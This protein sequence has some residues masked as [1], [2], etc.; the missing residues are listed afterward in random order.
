MSSPFYFPRTISRIVWSHWHSFLCNLI[1]LVTKVNLNFVTI[2]AVGTVINKT[3]HV[4]LSRCDF[5]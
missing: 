1:S 5:Q 2:R 3:M 4:K